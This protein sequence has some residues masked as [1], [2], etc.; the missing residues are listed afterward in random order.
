MI[1]A[2][3]AG[4][5]VTLSPRLGTANQQPL[6]DM[7]AEVTLLDG[8]GIFDDMMVANVLCRASVLLRED[9]NAN[10]CKAPTAIAGLAA[11]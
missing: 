6:V 7:T 11:L 1:Y 4:T 3:A 10:D 9:Q 2:D 5:N 8:S